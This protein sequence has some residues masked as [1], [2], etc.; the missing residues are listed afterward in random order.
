MKPQITSKRYI[1]TNINVLIISWLILLSISLSSE[2][3]AATDK[4]QKKEQEL[5]ELQSNIKTIRQELKKTQKALSS[6]EQVL[7]KAEIGIGELSKRVN[8]LERALKLQQDK[9]DDL[10]D[11]RQKKQLE[12][13]QQ[14]KLLKGQIRA[15]YATGRQEYL[16]IL[17]NQ[18]DPSTIGRMLTYY[19]YF[20][21]MRSKEIG[22]LGE[23]ITEIAAIETEVEV[24]QQRIFALRDQRLEELSELN[25]RQ[26]ERK[27]VLAQL[28]RQ[29]TTRDEQLTKMLKSQNELQSLI[30]ALGE[31]LADIPSA[32]QQLKSFRSQ[33][34]KMKWPTQGSIIARYGSERNLGKLKWNGVM[35]KAKEGNNVRAITHGRVVF[36]DWLRGYGLIIII[37]HGDGYMSLYGHNQS[38][39]KDVGDWVDKGEAIASVGN[40]GGFDQSALYFEIRHKGKPTNPRYWCRG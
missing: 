30:K 9:I 16:K 13:N 24:E 34:G 4:R 18:E 39:L 26:F 19:D 7:K 2:T 25:Q 28:K 5:K 6:Q 36:S 29:L 32:P 14:R 40:S 8:S 17:L 35:I 22:A 37:D 38:L 20:N 23:K 21:R 33:R 10:R 1:N 11:R 31:V 27:R 12:L 3:I 15:S